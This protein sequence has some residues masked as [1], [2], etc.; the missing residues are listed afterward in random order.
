[1]PNPTLPAVAP[2][3]GCPVAP[4]A[5]GLRAAPGPSPRLA[6]PIGVTPSRYLTRRG[7]DPSTRT[8]TGA[9]LA[10]TVTSL[11]SR[12]ACTRDARRGEI[13]PVSVQRAV[14]TATTSRTTPETALTA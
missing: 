11:V 1:M 13:S 2:L 4:P 8:A 6:T 5:A 14:T 3:A 10:R 12:C 7:L 9:A